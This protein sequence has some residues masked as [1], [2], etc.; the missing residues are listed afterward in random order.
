MLLLI[1]T[2]IGCYKTGI[3]SENGSKELSKLILTIVNPI[4]IFLAYQ[5]EFK[6]E[7]IK[8]FIS[9][10]ILSIFAY[11]IAMLLSYL[12]IRRK[13]GRETDIERF[14]CIYSN[15]AFMGIPL[16]QSIMGYEGVFYLTA[17]LTVFNILVWTHGVIQISGVRSFKF[18]LKALTSPSLLAIALG[19][20]C[21]L[22][23]LRLPGLLSDSLEFIGAMNTPLA[24]IVAG[25][26]IARTNIVNALKNPR[27]Y[28]VT[29]LTLIVIPLMTGVLFRLIPM[30]ESSELTVLVAMSAPAATMCTM[31]CLNYGKNSLYASE[32]F[33][34]TT[35]LSTLTMPLVVYFYKI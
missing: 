13:K 35:L 8:G 7:L 25:A 5:T 4:V 31:Q 2:G 17:F 29:V 14:S 19:L 28:Y 18:I 24:M 9:A 10:L 1:L 21:F 20:I 16:V 22:F 33:A 27:I 23:K 11:I 15:C 32:I 34:V 30:N 3:V 26:T 6:V 12:L